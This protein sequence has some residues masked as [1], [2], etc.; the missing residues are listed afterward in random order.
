MASSNPDSAPW[1]EGVAAA[2][3]HL[4]REIREWMPQMQTFDNTSTYS[5]HFQAWALPPPR[6]A[7]KPQ[8]SRPQTTEAFVTRSTMQD[9]FQPM[10]A[11]FRP[12][13]PFRPKSSYEP[14]VWMQPISTTHR[15]AFQQWRAPPRQSFKPSPANSRHT[16]AESF[17][18]RSTMQDSYQPVMKGTFVPTKSA[19]KEEVKYETGVFEGTTTSRASFQ[20]WPIP[21]RPAKKGPAQGL[22]FMGDAKNVMPNSTYRDQFREIT[23]PMGA[24]S[25][26]GLQVVNGKFFAM[27]PRGTR[28]PKVAT[29]TMTTTMDRQSSMDIVIVLSS[30]DYGRKGRKIGEFT[31][32]GIAPAKAGVPQVEVTFNLSTDNS[33]RVSA[34]DN[35]GSRQRALVVK[36][37]VRLG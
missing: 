32:D 2:Q 30:D 6:K 25:S 21:P 18:G 20:A 26:L 11:G 22:P 29:K 23:L 9:S 3:P 28:P 27:M 19:R 8:D 31:L 7:M 1:R 12:S 34:V 5:S 16:P 35:Q 36:E 33:L 4:Q 10:M 15:D 14:Q 24:S 37:R 17:T 13:Q